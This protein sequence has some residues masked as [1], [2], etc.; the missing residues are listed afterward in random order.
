VQSAIHNQDS[1]KPLTMTLEQEQTARTA[2]TG[3]G[4][5]ITHA[6]SV[7]DRRLLLAEVDALRELV[8][9]QS[10]AIEAGH[11]AIEAGHLAVQQMEV[12]PDGENPA[13]IRL[14]Q[15]HLNKSQVFN[16]ARVT[17]SQVFDAAH[18]TLGVPSPFGNGQASPL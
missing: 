14:H 1:M 16:S 6:P 18:A 11:L 4:P 7:I 5:V 13:S 10:K 9:L 2:D 8:A 3:W 17:L 12:D 15:D